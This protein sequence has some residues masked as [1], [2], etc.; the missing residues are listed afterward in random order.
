MLES[1][2]LIQSVQGP[3][4]NCGHTLDLVITRS[5]H[6]PPVI[7][8]DPPLISDHSVVSFELRLQRP[9]IRMI[10]VDTRSWKGF[11]EDKF[12]SDL[13][14][15]QLCSSLNDYANLSVDELQ[16]IYDTTLSSLLDKHAPK[17]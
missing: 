14:K 2:G 12:R 5:D 7:K 17:R 10:D 11:N 16:E 13:L 8:V 1:F 4:H 6:D 3:T 9:P 15:S